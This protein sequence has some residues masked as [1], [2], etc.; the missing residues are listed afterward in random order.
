[1]NEC[2]YKTN[3]WTYT[4]MIQYSDTLDDGMQ[5]YDIYVKSW[6]LCLGNECRKCA[7]LMIELWGLES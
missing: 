4:N 7:G 5:E 6:L 3:A 2:M 1:M